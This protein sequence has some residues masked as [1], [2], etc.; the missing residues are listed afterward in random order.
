MLKCQQHNNIFQRV[1]RLLA[2]CKWLGQNTQEDDQPV[3][4]S[5]L[6]SIDLPSCAQGI[7]PILCALVERLIN[8]Q[9]DEDGK[10]VEGSHFA[11]SCTCRGGGREAALHMACVVCC[12]L[13]VCIEVSVEYVHVLMSIQQAVSLLAGG[14]S[15][16][17]TRRHQSPLPLQPRSPHCTSHGPLPESR[18]SRDDPVHKRGLH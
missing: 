8:S 15:L 17:H 1:S 18:P 2:I 13:H 9:L 4:E 6:I 14:A 10:Q 11:V 12:G 3:H 5:F 16:L 7:V